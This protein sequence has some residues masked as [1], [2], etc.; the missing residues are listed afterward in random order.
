SILVWG[1]ANGA[2]TMQYPG[3]TLIVNQGDT[4]TI[5]LRNELSVPTSIVFPGQQGLTA[6]GGSAGL[7]TRE[8]PPDNGATVVTYTFT[9]ANAGTYLYHSGSRPDLQVEMGLVGAIIVRPTGFDPVTNRRVYG[10]PGSAYDHEY[11]FLFTEMDPRI[12]ELVNTGRMAE[13]DTT[14][15]FPVYW[16]INGRNAPDTM[17]EAGAPWLPTQPYNCLPRMRPGERLLMRVVNAGR[18]LHPFHHHGNNTT[19]I[20]RDGR[21]LESAPGAGPDLA[22]SDF[23]IKAVPGETYDAIYEWTG[24]GLGWDIYGHA[25]GDPLEPNEYAPDHGKPF[26]V[27][28]PNQQDL[29]FGGFYSGSPFLGVFGPLPPGQGGLNLNAGFF[30]M[31]HSHTEKEIVNFDIFP[32]GMMTMV[33]IEPPGTPIP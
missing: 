2:G 14:T 32:G 3:P 18:D 33:I 20:A 16:F 13:V 9:A 30:H 28:L 15:Y 31:W 27:V 19:L 12:H 21:M 22:V 10:H 7:L 4:I 11:L 6:T 24:K 8:A 29:T 17:A 25:P 1:Y 26:P 23:T 5:R